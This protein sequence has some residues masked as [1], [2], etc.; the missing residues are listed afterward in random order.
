MQISFVSA[1]NPEDVHKPVSRLVCLENTANRGGGSCYEF[2]DIQGIKE[3]C[4][5]NNLK[6]HLDGARLFNALVEKKQTRQHT[7]K[8]STAFPF[9]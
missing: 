2:D 1:I 5:L 8:F 9:A 4:L 7:V 3:V 6:L